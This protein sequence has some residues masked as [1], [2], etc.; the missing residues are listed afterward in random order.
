MRLPVRA[1]HSLSFC[2]PFCQL[3][4]T[5]SCGFVQVLPSFNFKY[6]LVLGIRFPLAVRA[7]CKVLTCFGVPLEIVQASSEERSLIFV[8]VSV[9]FH[10][11]NTFAHA[12]FQT[13]KIISR[14]IKESVADMI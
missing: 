9:P 6:Q 7:C 3:E 2:P 12:L 13:F 8:S 5:A 11:A 1:R 14:R 10:L 4:G